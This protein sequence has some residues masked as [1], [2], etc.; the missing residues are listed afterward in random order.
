MRSML[1]TERVAALRAQ[2]HSLRAIAAM[3]ST[4]LAAVQRALARRPPPEPVEAEDDDPFEVD[5]RD[6]DG[7]ELAMLRAARWTWTRLPCSSRRSCTTVSTMAFCAG[8]TPTVAASVRS[9]CTGG[10]MRLH[11]P[12]TPTEWRCARR[13]D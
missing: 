11:E 9:T 10:R 12:P 8:V 7:G 4:S 1:D 3:L 6:C 2:G 13:R 5:P